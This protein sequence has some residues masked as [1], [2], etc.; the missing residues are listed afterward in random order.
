[1]SIIENYDEFKKEIM[2]KTGLKGK[3]LFKPLRIILTG[4]ENGPE[5]TKLYPFL[6]SYILELIQKV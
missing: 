1:M 5:L 4:A 6:K 3:M 2:L